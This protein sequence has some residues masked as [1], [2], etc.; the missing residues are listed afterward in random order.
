MVQN[1][2]WKIIMSSIHNLN[3]KSAHYIARKSSTGVWSNIYRA[4]NHLHDI[5]IDHKSLFKLI[6]ESTYC[7]LLGDCISKVGFSW[8]WKI[9]NPASFEELN[10]LL[11]LYNVIGDLNI[12][13][14][15]KYGFRFILSPNGDYTVKYMRKLINSKLI[16]YSGPNICWRFL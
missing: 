5:N 8:N 16:T 4:V 2:L 10:E 3:D 7:F 14:S 11:Q 15:S 6:P 13:G 12:D 9:K 1:S